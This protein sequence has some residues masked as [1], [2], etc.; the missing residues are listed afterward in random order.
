MKVTQ[1]ELQSGVQRPAE[2]DTHKV[3]STEWAVSIVYERSQVNR[4]S[5]KSKTQNTE[6]KKSVSHR[7]ET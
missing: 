4:K 5:L 1:V 7:P 2:K 6:S 3:S